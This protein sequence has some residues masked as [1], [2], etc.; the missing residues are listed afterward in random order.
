MVPATGDEKTFLRS[1]GIV[2][3]VAMQHRDNAAEPL[4]LSLGLCNIRFASGDL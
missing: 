1:T 4:P 3:R 2:N